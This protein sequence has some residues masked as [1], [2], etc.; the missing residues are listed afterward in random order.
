MKKM[1][2]R[3]IISPPPK[4]YWRKTLNYVFGGFNFLMWIAFIVTIISYQPL[5]GPNPSSFNLG[6]AILLV[7]CFINLSALQ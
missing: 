3:N 5:G 6:V 7:Y 1:Y 4:H 2:G